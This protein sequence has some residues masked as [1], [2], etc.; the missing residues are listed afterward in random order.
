VRVTGT[1]KDRDKVNRREVCRI[2]NVANLR[3]EL[4]VITYTGTHAFRVKL[5]EVMTCFITR[6]KVV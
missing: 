4:V 5:Q 3:F 1:P 6:K 2:E